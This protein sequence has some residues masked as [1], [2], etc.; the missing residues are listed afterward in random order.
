MGDKA[1]GKDGGKTKK[2]PKAAKGGLRPHEERA[3]QAS[4]GAA[5]L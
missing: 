2:K 4:Q 5:G 1:K 3:R